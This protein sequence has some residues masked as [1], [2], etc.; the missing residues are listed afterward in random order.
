VLR[1]ETV[2]AGRYR[3]LSVIG[4]G[5][6][7]K[8]YLAEDLRI[9]R[10]VAIKELLAY[11]DALSSEERQDH[12]RR[13]RK[14]A[15]I[16]SQFTHP[17]VVCA[18]ALETD[19]EG[20]EYLILEH[21]DGESLEQLLDEESPLG[22]E[23]ALGITMDICRAVEAISA[24]DI[25][26]RD[27]KPGNILLTREGVARLTGFGVA[28]VGQEMHRTQQA[29]G[30]PGTPAYKSPE[31]ANS[32][33]CLDQRS[34]LYALGLVTY[35]MLT[36]RRYLRHGRSVCYYNRDVPQAL[37]AVIMKALEESPAARYQSAA[38]MLRDLERVANQSAWGQARVLLKRACSSRHAA[39]VAIV[40]LLTLTLSIYRLSA[41]VS[42]SPGPPAREMSI[43]RDLAEVPGPVEAP[44]YPW[45]A[46]P[47]SASPPPEE[48][49]FG[50]TTTPAD[51]YQRDVYESD[52]RAPVPISI[53]ETQRRIFDPEGDVDR[54]TFRVKAGRTYVVS[55]ANLSVGVDTSIVVLVGEQKLAN[56]DISP[57][58]LASQ[59]S[60][61]AVEDGTAVVTVR[62]QDQYGPGRAYDLSLVMVLPTA[63]ATSSSTPSP[64]VTPTG[65]AGA[66][67]TPRPTYTP[68]P[69]RTRTPTKTRTRTR[70]PTK[71]RTPRPTQTRT[72]TLTQTASNTPT[73]TG[74]RSPT[75]TRTPTKTAT[76]DRTP[77]PV[78]TDAPPVK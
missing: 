78:R 71:T 47:G 15:Q 46:T 33:E 62:N 39:A 51:A 60:F 17:N 66:T 18:H 4:E 9:D 22:V 30:H 77:L 64:T 3:I 28:Q 5:G 40:V 45:T 20:N 43:A 1:P 44:T 32:T 38:E 55:A 76:P 49:G 37:D 73:A 61:T 10:A 2:L 36:G 23:R 53:G 25:V 27:I 35:E 41:A 69:T 58:A 52:D 65:T 29:L 26:H 56:D 54:V 57:G 16:A 21:G 74:T 70:I 31:Q 67:L 8:V 59:V 75:A 6:F 63:T 68:G 24:R 72:V 12:Q 14:E 50:P 13:F 7:G 48:A 34:D 11:P 42:S 19:A